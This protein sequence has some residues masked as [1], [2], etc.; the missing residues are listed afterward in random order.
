MESVRPEIMLDDW[1]RREE[2][3]GRSVITFVAI[4]NVGRGAALHVIVNGTKL[5]SK[6]PVAVLS[7][8]HIPIIAPNG[9]LEADNEI[10]VWWQNVT[11]NE[12]KSLHL[13]L[14]VMCWDSYEQRHETTYRLLV[15][16]DEIGVGGVI[17]LAPGVRLLNRTSITKSVRRLRFSAWIDRVMR[18]RR[19]VTGG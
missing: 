8:L 6:R 9:S 11:G 14:T 17:T 2:P 1:A 10:N 16:Q 13:P 19:G 12:H 15:M 18:R 3:D 5:I 4:R 7:T